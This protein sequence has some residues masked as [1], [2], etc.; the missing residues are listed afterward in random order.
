M[1]GEAQELNRGD[2]QASLP[3]ARRELM[4]AQPGRQHGD[5]EQ[6]MKRRMILE[7]E[8]TRQDF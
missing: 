7:V 6:R 4:E 3:W 1:D 8:L 2:L 5:G